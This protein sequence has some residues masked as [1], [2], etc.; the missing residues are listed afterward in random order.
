MTPPTPLA[1]P[2][3]RLRRGGAT[4]QI[5]I[6]V[7]A[8]VAAALGHVHLRLAVL[9]A[10]YQLSEESHLCRALGDQNQKLRLELDTRRD[11]AVVERRARAELHMAPPEGSAIRTL[12]VPPTP[13]SPSPSPT[14]PTPTPTT[15]TT[16][17]AL[18]PARTRTPAPAPAP[19]AGSVAEGAR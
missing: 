11:P 16:P 10:G 12:S 2:P 3:A 1:P 13:P 6:V 8:V 19:T 4:F 17:P 18:T 7:A 14:M 5:A 15:R 9:Q